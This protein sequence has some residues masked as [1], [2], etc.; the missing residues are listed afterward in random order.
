M[1]PTNRRQQRRLYVQLR[2]ES[3]MVLPM[4]PWL[5][6]T[7]VAEK[8]ESSGKVAEGTDE[9]AELRREIIAGRAAAVA[10]KAAVTKFDKG[11]KTRLGSKATKSGPASGKKQREAG[12]STTPIF[13]LKLGCHI[14]RC[15]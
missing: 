11:E 5:E 15:P 9:H 10:V 6:V 7:R 3:G 4:R 13:Q 12:P 14:S 8:K 1:S 2:L